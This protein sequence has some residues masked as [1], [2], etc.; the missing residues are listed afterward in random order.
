M[1]IKRQREKERKRKIDIG[2]WRVEKKKNICITNKRM[3]MIWF[4]V[5]ICLWRQRS[6][7]ENT[8]HK[9]PSKHTNVSKSH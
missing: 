4:D 8:E 9:L 2:W 6:L 3:R 1:I 5:E 7:L